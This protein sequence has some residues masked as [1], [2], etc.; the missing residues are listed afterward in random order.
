MSMCYFN[1]L[2]KRNALFSIIIFANEEYVYFNWDKTNS[3]YLFDKEEDLIL[4]LTTDVRT[5]LQTSGFWSQFCKQKWERVNFL[6]FFS[7]GDEIKLLFIVPLSK[8]NKEKSNYK[9]I[10]TLSLLT[11][12]KE[13]M[14][15]INSETNCIYTS[16]IY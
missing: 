15:F 6:R 7:H 2:K 11:Y 9:G 8:H 5:N 10:S 12:I 3:Y 1:F 16:T 13:D 14:C 4:S